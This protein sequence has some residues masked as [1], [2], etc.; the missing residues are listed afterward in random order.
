MS[1]KKIVIINYK[2]KACDIVF[3]SCANF[4]GCCYLN[5]LTHTTEKKRREEKKILRNRIII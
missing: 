5:T 4:D 3:I 2:E 1:K